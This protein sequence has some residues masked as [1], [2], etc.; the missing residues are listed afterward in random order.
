MKR[1]FWAFTAA[2]L[3]VGLLAAPASADPKPGMTFSTKGLNAWADAYF[4]GP[5]GEAGLHVQGA[6][7]TTTRVKMPG[8]QPEGYADDTSIIGFWS[9]TGT[10]GVEVTCITGT[11][12]DMD[13][14]LDTATMRVE[15]CEAT[16]VEW[17]CGPGPEDSCFPEEV[18]TVLLS[19]DVEWTGIGDEFRHRYNGRAS[20][21]GYWEMWR[22]SG[23]QREA[24]V[25]G[26]VDVDGVSYNLDNALHAS[27][28]LARVRDWTS[29]RG[30]A[31]W[32]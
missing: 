26:E 6:A 1:Q 15:D 16:V 32:E 2:V 19:A 22:S 14:A 18:G 25:T 8:S 11:G 13:R 23:T 7:D 12:F 24:Q 9:Q 10:G 4:A 20:S 27:G 30:S 17:V 5:D 3:A 28:S 21:S 31:P 29:S